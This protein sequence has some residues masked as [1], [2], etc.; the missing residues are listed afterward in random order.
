MRGWPAATIAFYGPDA[1]RATKVAVGI[2]MRDEDEPREMRDWSTATGDVR[3]NAAIATEILGFIEKHGA[4]SIIMTDRIIGC[5]HQTGIDYEGD[6]CP[7]PACA[8]WYK[9]DRFTGELIQ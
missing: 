7:D 4:L 6:W 1:K 5:P 9:R 8:Y 3:N 2:V